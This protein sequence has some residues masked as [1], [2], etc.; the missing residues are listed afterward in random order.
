LPNQNVLFELGYFFSAF[1][2]SRIALVKYGT[3]HIPK[4]LDGYTHI[5][6]SKFF[7]AGASTTA[8]KR[9]KEDFA[10]WTKQLA[11][12]VKKK[13]SDEDARFSLID[14][15]ADDIEKQFLILMHETGNEVSRFSPFIYERHDGAGTG[16]LG[17]L[18]RGNRLEGTGL[19]RITGNGE[20]W[21]LT[22]EGH[23]FAAWLILKRR[24]C[25]YFW[26]PFGTW[27]TPIPGGNAEKYLKERHP[28]KNPTN[29]ATLQTP[30]RVT[31]IV[32]VPAAVPFTASTVPRVHSDKSRVTVIASDGRPVANAAVLA[33][34]GNNTTK[35]A[36]TDAA[37]CAVLTIAA[38]RTY[39]LLIAH[40]DLPGAVVRSWDPKEDITVTLFATENVGSILC[41]GGTGHIPGLEGRLNP[42]LDAGNR[43]Y[44]YADNIA[45]DGGK[46]QPSSFEINVPFKL[47]DCDGVVMEVRILHIQGRTSLLEFVRPAPRA[48]GESASQ[49][50]S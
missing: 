25:T 27:G 18:G 15:L 46:P 7:K 48:S 8:G 19:V 45:I 43:M 24:K 35:Q 5:R 36:R 37:G 34:A 17:V 39:Q 40:P 26:S 23:S 1:D 47:E 31:S 20:Y 50:G 3:T 44:L 6:G 4:D 11:K 32:P 29:Q 10:K 33:I 12:S 16:S 41:A 2:A 38:H 28:E 30:A 49:L 13:P 21:S 14:L 9:T 42:I 22:D